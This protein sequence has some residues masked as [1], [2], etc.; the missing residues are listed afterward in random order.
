MISNETFMK[1]HQ[2]VTDWQGKEN[3]RVP[4]EV[5]RQIFNTHNEIFPSNPEFSVGCGGCRER[6]WR[7][8]KDWYHE[9]KH[10]WGY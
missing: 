9:N 6:V 4:A 1:T 2:L 8:L 10:E 3:Q 5:I 7:K